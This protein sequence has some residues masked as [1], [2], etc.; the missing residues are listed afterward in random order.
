MPDPGIIIRRPETEADHAAIRSLCRAYRESLARRATHCPD[1]VEK[2]Y[3]ERSY[4]A[5]LIQLPA[6][7]ARPKGALFLA[8]LNASP[9]GCAMTH[10][11]APGRAEIKRLYV[12]RQARGHGAARLLI[13]AAMEQAREDG[14]AEMVLDTMAWLHEAIALYERLG[15]TPCAPFYDP[16]P[17]YAPHLRF[18]SHP[19]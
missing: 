3:S 18:F 7:H 17:R 13:R 15:F 9:V 1:I 5:L 4:E 14:H 2:Y 10:E 19:L 6:L 12:S 11:V 16:E 8:C